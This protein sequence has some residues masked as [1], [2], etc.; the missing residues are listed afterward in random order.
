M[1]GC[2]ESASALV[3]KANPPRGGGAKPGVSRT[4][5]DGPAAEGALLPFP[6]AGR[7]VRSCVEPAGDRSLEGV[8]HVRCSSGPHAV[9]RRAVLHRRPRRRGGAGA[10]G[11][12]RESPHPGIHDQPLAAQP[13]RRPRGPFPRR[14]EP[15]ALGPADERRARH[16]AAVVPAR[17]VVGRFQLHPRCQ[18]GRAVDV[19]RDVRPRLRRAG[20]HHRQG[21]DQRRVRVPVDQ[22][23]FVRGRVA[24]QRR[25][26]VHPAAQ[27]LLPG[28]RQPPHGADQL[29]SGVRARPAAGEPVGR[30][31]LA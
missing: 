13:A 7:R 8:S 16:R 24:R 23:R 12:P 25:A 9:V 20:D 30:H 5:R 21:P 6:S 17:L 22:L 10:A 18:D 26:L 15:V 4:A 14:R 2:D 29:R 19:E 31:Q 1:R 27:R 28:Q 11:R 3:Q